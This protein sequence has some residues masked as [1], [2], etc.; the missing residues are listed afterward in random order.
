MHIVPVILA[1]GEGARLW[2]LSRPD[3]P[4]AFLN[5]DGEC[6]L[7]QR[8]AQRVS[9]YA[10]PVVVC[11]E[12]HRFQVAGQLR[13][14][15]L[16]AKT[17][18]LEPKLR[19]TAAA[20]TSAAWWLAGQGDAAVMLILPADHVI[21]EEDAF[22]AAV[23][24]AAT[25]AAGGDMVCIGVKAERADSS[26]G[27]VMIDEPLH[28]GGGYHVAHFHEKPDVATAAAYLQTG[29]AYWNSGIYVCTPFVLLEL[30]RQHAA[31]I[32]GATQRAV[33]QAGHD[34]DFVWLEDSAYASCPSVPLDVAVME[35]AARR[36]M[37]P[38]RMGWRDV[39]SFASLW[40]AAQKDEDGN[41]ITGDV[42]LQH[43]QRNYVHSEHAPVAVIGMQDVMV[44]NTP[45]ALLVAKREAL[46]ALKPLLAAWPALRDSA[47]GCR[48]Q[49][50]WGYYDVLHAGEQVQVKTL[51]IHPHAQMSLQRH[52]YRSEHWVVVSG[53]AL[54]TRGIER[55]HVRA[56]ESVFVPQGCMHRLG[57]AL[58][59][60]LHILEVQTGSYL[61]ED[62]I[63]RFADDFG[64]A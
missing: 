32:A 52:Q 27:Y 35:R 17:V 55:L 33:E 2:P 1:G 28:D 8:T 60:P 57:N 63:E 19:N 4:K 3:T 7:L 31:A 42:Q 49:R 9:G 14:Q 47:S 20:V 16:A 40:E 44:V 48:V 56:G 10:P 51:V 12:A 24:E 26:Y 58:D 22:H 50:P 39:G 18:L 43:A 25:L 62:D 59:E 30:M 13:Q 36:A 64:R 46:D 23:Q 61:G 5:L 53:E 38:A 6:S 21:A 45:D 29:R 34:T 37:V 15:G 11:L 54:V 41:A